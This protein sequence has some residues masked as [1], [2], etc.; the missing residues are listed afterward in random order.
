MRKDFVHL[1][2]HTEYSLLDGF[3]TINKV[4]DKVK[5]L[6]M[7]SIAITDH[8]TMFGIVDFYKAAIKKGIKPIIG[9]EVYTASRG[10]RDKDPNK[11]KYQ[12][13]LV[14][15][16]KNM[17]GYQNLLKLVSH[18][19]L[20]GFY[21]KPRVDYAELAKYNKG[22]IA[23][24]GCLAGDIQQ[25]LLK[26]SYE[27][28]KE[29]ALQLQ[30]I[31]GEGNFYLELQDH[32][33]KEQK[34]VNYQLLKLSK[35]TGIP[36]VAT[37]DVH[38]INK[39]DA[40]PHDILLCIQTGKIQEEKERMKFPNHEFYMKAPEEM[41]ALFP[42]IESALENTVKIAEACNVEF[43]FNT[44][45]LPEYITPEGFSVEDYLKSLCYQGLEERYTQPSKELKDRLEYELRVIEEMGYE[46]YFLIVWDFI[47]F[48]KDNSIPVGP[49][50]GSAAGSIVAYTLGITDIDPIRYS[51]IF[52]RFLNPERVSMPDIDIDFCYERREAVIEYVKKKYG[53]DKVAQIITFGTMAAR[54]AIRDVGRVIN[55]PYH[56][57]DKIAKEV[58][59][60]VGMTLEKALEMN[61]QLKKLYKEDQEAGYLIEMAKKLEGMPRHASTH[62]AGVVISKKALEEH[63][64][65]YMHDQSVTTQF[66]MGTLE[67]LGLLK[68][69]F[70]GLRTLTVIRDTI[71]L[72]EKNKG[73][74]IDFSICTY[75]DE[76]VYDLIIKGET[77][78]VF[79]LESA[80][81][82]Q[83]MKEL[84]PNCIEDVIAGISLFRPGP[85]DSI[86][87]YI[88]NKNDPSKVQYLHQK[89][90]S[91]LEVTYGCLV[92][93]EQVMQVVRDLAGYSYGRSD[94]VRRAM[95]KKK[96]D[97]MEEERQY[98]IHGK[99]DEDGNIEIAGCIRNGV[100]EDIANKIYDDMIDF[101][102]YAFNK[103]HA[104]AYAVLGYQTAYL[105]VHYPVEFMAA[106]ITSVMGNT[107]KVAQYIQ[108]CKRLGIEILPPDINRSFGRFTVEKN[109]IRYGLAAVKNVGVNMIEA[110]VIIREK[111]GNFSSFNDFCQKVDG[112]DLNKRAVESLIK[113][114]AFDSL[115]VYRAQLM[116]VYE[117]VLESVSQDKK[118]NI[119]GQIGLFQMTGET[120]IGL[121][122][123][124]L[125]NIK[126]FN[127]KIK[128]NMEK[129]VIGLY[130]SGHPLSEFQQELRYLATVNSSHLLEMM[131]N[132]QGVNNKDGKVVR[133]GGVIVEKVTKTTKNN[134]LMA[135]IT[136]EDLFGT[137][138]C[139]IFPKTLN[140]YTELIKEDTIVIIEGTLNLKD[141]EK[142][143]ILANKIQPLVKMEDNKLYIKINRKEDIVLI[144]KA[145]NIFKKYHG[146]VPVY[147]YIQKENKTLR[148][149][150]DLW[151]KLNDQLM[152]ELSE[153]FGEKAI[154]IK[155]IS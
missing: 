86:P 98:F 96:R 8:G 5:D 28:A 43:D 149:D 139:I 118:R 89:L 88:A 136:L 22:L 51:L 82:I 50:R 47:K 132:P 151:V 55:M 26:D 140:E 31:Y 61:P 64:P 62:A 102:N 145:K 4:M 41:S 110:M 38:Y 11:D 2:V 30:R 93:Q 116:A 52:E 123:D 72:I 87:K 129:E 70:L 108:D 103:S 100:P 57:V 24:S 29:T 79:Q 121:K 46:E 119:E 111:K 101:A 49:G 137:I 12:G 1:H 71:E 32:G 133:V 75:D 125:P 154:K 23:L 15:L 131:E 141:E 126:E 9:C 105:K 114:G 34:E 99:T 144:E 135:F 77:L 19:Y 150:R 74:K 117:R 53:A 134:Q 3:T 16:A 69:D 85:M 65:L 115:K 40:E 60:A 106:L 122:E 13:H 10:M 90:K 153:V 67:D 33:L 44:I 66:T 113:C 152:K 146:N 14:L 25:Y 7:K 20:Y 73:K 27:K 54:A 81:M 68:M 143:K 127:D 148:A 95:S 18:S 109:K 120:S 63:V 6:G 147:V 138:E 130:I 59:F 83:F 84:K 94:L 107:S 76:K 142:P 124:I 17:E 37:N 80:G 78:G 155:S 97:V 58:P 112:K 48:A 45:H 56:V 21:Y 35:D 36:L 128:L 91:I 42:N 92:Y 104:A 39:E